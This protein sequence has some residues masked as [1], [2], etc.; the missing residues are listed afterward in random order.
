[1]AEVL[2]TSHSNPLPSLETV[3]FTVFFDQLVAPTAA[4][5]YATVMAPVGFDQQ[6]LAS[7]SV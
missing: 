4:Q 3:V 1:M 2:R 5:N 7:P 6:L